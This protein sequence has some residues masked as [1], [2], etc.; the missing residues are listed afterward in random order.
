MKLSILNKTHYGL[1]IYAHILKQYYPK[2]EYV[3]KLVGNK[4]EPTRNP[5]NKNRRTLY[6]HNN[7]SIFLFKDTELDNYCGDPFDFSEKH[8]GIKGDELLN[9]I[10]TE[11]YL[12]VKEKNK[13]YNSQH[14]YSPVKHELKLPEFSF[15][16]R[17]IKNIIPNKTVNLK[18]VYNLIKYDH[19]KE[20]TIVLRK[21]RNTENARIYKVHNFNYVTFSGIFEK[22][23]N[24]SLVKHSGLIVIDFDHVPNL[25]RLKT[26]LLNDEYFE[27]ELMFISPSGDGL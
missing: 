10:N 16:K 5:F 17:P 13:F 15:F 2:D 11:L 24:N 22:R 19:Y 4:C 14:I 1:G 25:K 8:Y 9:K 18:Y 6:I 26:D 27:T 21:L 23:S 20:E 3:I 12:H 7:N